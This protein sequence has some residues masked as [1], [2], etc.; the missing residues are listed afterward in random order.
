MNVENATSAILFGRI[1]E[2][3][4]LPSEPRSAIWCEERRLFASKLD[5]IVLD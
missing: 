3:S 2:L 4:A 5:G 1:G